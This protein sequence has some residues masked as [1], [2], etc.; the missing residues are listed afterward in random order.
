MLGKA[1]LIVAKQRN[2]ATGDVKLHWFPEYTTFKTPSARP[3]DEF[4]QYEAAEKDF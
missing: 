4:E 3:Y 2:G 1:D